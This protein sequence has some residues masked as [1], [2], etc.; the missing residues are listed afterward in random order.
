[1]R[2]LT[3]ATVALAAHAALL[4]AQQPAAARGT[5]RDSV[6]GATI[7][8]A[9]VFVDSGPITHT[10]P[11]GGYLLPG[12]VPPSTTIHVRR[13]GY[14]TAVR[15]IALVPGDTVHLD[16]L[17][18][19]TSLELAPV[20]VTAG[21]RSQLLEQ[22][23]TSVALV[24]PT[25]LARRGVATVDEAVDKAPGV[26]FLGGQVNIRGS[27]GF[28]VGIG[29]RVLLLMDGVPANQGDRGGI[30]WDLV[31][32]D[33]IDR[34]EIVKGAGSSLYG[35]AALGG[36][37]NLISRDVPTG[38]HMRVRA[39]GGGFSNPPDTIWRFRDYT[40][41]EELLAATGSYGGSALRG[42]LT[43]VG[44]H[45]DG[46]RQQDRGETWQ[47][48]G[49]GDWIASSSTRLHAAGA[50]ASHRY[51]VP[52]VWC[53]HGACDDRG[54]AYQPFK[55][56]T[57]RSLDAYTTSNKSLLA[58]TLDHVA[59]SRF[60]FLA[61]GSWLHSDFNDIRVPTGEA[62]ASDRYGLELRAVA[63]SNGDRVSTVGGEVASTGTSGDAFG[64]HTITEVAGYGEGEE[65]WGATRLTAGGRVDFVERDGGGGTA[66]IS[67]RVGVVIPGGV[68]W[69]A[70]AG[71]AFRAP[72]L[73]EL[74]PTSCLPGGVCAK[75][76]PDLDPET[77]WS[78][79]VGAL[80]LPGRV[81]RLD[82]A[83]FW[84]EAEHYI[85]PAVS[86]DGL[87]IQFQNLQRARIAGLDLSATATTLASRLTTSLAYTFL[88][89]RELAHDTVPERPLAFRPR[90]L[91]T[92]GADYAL[93]PFS[94]GA[95]FRYMSAYERVELYSP[96]IPLLSPKVLDARASFTR[97][98]LEV[99][100]LVANALNYL[101]NLVPQTLAPARTATLS[102][103]WSH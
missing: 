66:M 40:G 32:L 33:A 84:T 75:P 80:A 83:V 63:H 39:T 18:A 95:D 20:I 56:D 22:A 49:Q 43:A 70:S 90:H 36:V 97:G 14:R 34:V 52:L 55:V 27:S 38:F 54:Q 59:S 58:A 79:E 81:A 4:T 7:P 12:L 103:A 9:Q 96:L 92:L 68:T 24:T 78:F 93:G 17:L 41:G 48:A 94:V 82:A 19:P 102:V 5:V 89:A 13:L 76:N 77:A 73:A 42:S 67:P 60:A 100:L 51:E 31:P 29:S 6:T 101:Y 10:D 64:A 45:T 86:P 30:D 69:R 28:Q 1:V 87:E 88:Y 16:F 61:R 11:S 26:Q 37:V 35:S 57:I 47:V 15:T 8:D 3:L 62:G 21:K 71:R 72:S 98:V 44:R 2:A 65:R 50:W 25:D 53:E 46:Y 91:V 99:R 85:E 23:V 74:Y